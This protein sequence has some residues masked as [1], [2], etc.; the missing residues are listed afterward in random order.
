MNTLQACD[1]NVPFRG[2]DHDRHFGNVGLGGN[3]VQESDDGGFGIE[4]AF[5]HVHVD[6]LG[7]VFHLFAG[8]RQGGVVVVFQNQALEF[9]RAGHVTALADVDEEGVRRNGKGLETAQSA[10][11]FSCRNLARLYVRDRGAN[12]FNVGRRGAATA[13]DQI[14]VAAL[15]EIAQ[16]AAHVVGG[17]VVLAEFIGQAGIEMAA[18]IALGHVRQFFKEGPDF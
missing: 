4:H 9:G 18:D 10:G 5:V 14:Q 7:A 2:V 1:D 3:Q 11:N 13:A 15:A 17:F 12:F 16:F 6:N 8:N